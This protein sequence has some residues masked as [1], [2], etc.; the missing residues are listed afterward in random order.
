MAVVSLLVALSGV[1]LASVESAAAAV[2]SSKLTISGPSSGHLVL[3]PS[4]P[5]VRLGDCLAFVNATNGQV[6]LTV[7][8]ADKTVYAATLAKGETTSKKASFA[9]SALGRDT[10]TA[11]SKAVLVLTVKGSAI[12]TVSPSPSASPTATGSPSPRGKGSSK[13]AK[14]PDVA[15]SP[16]HSKK[17]PSPKPTGIKLPPLPPLPSTGSTAAGVPLGSNPLV[18]PGPTS[19]PVTGESQSPVAEVIAG[20]LEPPDNDSRGLPVA[21]GVIVVLGLATGWGR[22]LL[23]APQAVDDRSRGDHRL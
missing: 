4:A 5:K 21:V 19:A 6:S 7:A 14:G 20:P 10:V 22:V 13:P 18:A 15:P 9:P 23:A 12:I 17:H 1:M 2:C 11:T 8:H 3:S 16:K